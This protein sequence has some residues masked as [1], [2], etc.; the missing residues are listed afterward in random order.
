M[1]NRSSLRAPRSKRAAWA[2]VRTGT[3]P[4]FAAMPPNAPLVTSV[5][6]APSSAARSAAMTPAGPAPTT[7]TFRASEGM[8]NDE[9]EVVPL[10]RVDGPELPLR[11]QPQRP[12]RPRR[13][14][15][16]GAGPEVAVR[17]RRRR[18]LPRKLPDGEPG[19]AGL[20][21]PLAG[22]QRL[23]ES[24]VDHH[25]VA[26]LRAGLFLLEVLLDT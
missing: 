24:P 3:G 12:S 25:V 13:R 14:A 17:P 16:L 6:R 18:L 20:D 15:R 5:V 23:A 7:T 10:D 11:A 8:V 2:S 26:R 21:R 4:S 22:A 1:P 9:P 19:D